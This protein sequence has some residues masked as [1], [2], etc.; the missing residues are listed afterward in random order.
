MVRSA[1]TGTGSPAWRC[2]SHPGKVGS[3]GKPSCGRVYVGAAALEE[4][5]V[6]AMFKWADTTKLARLVRTRTADEEKAASLSAR[7]ADVERRLNE[8]ADSY[9]S[10]RLSLHSYERLTIRL[11]GQERQI[12]A[13]VSRLG[14]SSP[15]DRYVGRPG[16]LRAEWDNLSLDEK[17]AALK[18]SVGPVAILPA[19]R[20]GRPFFD[21]DRVVAANGFVPVRARGS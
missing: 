19:I 14:S 18:E 11:E 15:L 9:A 7:L 12:R 3:D 4:D 20:P 5:I 6:E 1:Y 16:A 10:G 13:Q 8:A 2:P 17:R 21:K